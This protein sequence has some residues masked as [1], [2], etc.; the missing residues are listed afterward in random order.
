MIYPINNYSITS[1]NYQ[2]KNNP[3][4]TGLNNPKIRSIADVE[5]DEYFGFTDAEVRNL[6][7]YYEIMDHYDIVKEWYDGYR[8]G[9]IDVYCPWDVMNYMLE[10]TRNP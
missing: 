2:N 10:L 4:F 1:L 8:F 5:F 3:N 7:Q 6:L 9:N